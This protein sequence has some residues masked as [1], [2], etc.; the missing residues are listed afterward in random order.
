MSVPARFDRI[1]QVNFKGVWLC[2]KAQLEQMVRQGS[3]SIVNTASLAGLAGFKTTCGYAA[4]KHGVVGL[5][6]TA[7]IEYAP[8]I[9]V[10][11][12]C[13]GFVDTDMLT[14]TMARR[15]DSGAGAVRR[16]GQAR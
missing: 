15:R 16:A 2:M 3:G 12:V 9:R 11:C 1:I 13:P 5:T 4:S 14:D 8:R 10:N 7:A 6:K